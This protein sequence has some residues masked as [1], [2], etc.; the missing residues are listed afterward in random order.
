MWA[1][2]ACAWGDRTPEAVAELEELD[3]EMDALHDDLRGQLQG[4]VLPIVPAVEMAL[5]GRF[6][7]RLGDHALHVTERLG[8]AAGA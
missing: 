6:Y 7:E 4:G 2:A 5:V 8:Y 3:D 1:T